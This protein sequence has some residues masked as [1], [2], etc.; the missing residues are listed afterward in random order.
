MEVFNTIECE[1]I[2]KDT[3]F[4]F[5]HGSQDGRINS[6]KDEDVVLDWL[7]G[8]ESLRGKI[9]RKKTTREIADF[10]IG[11]IPVN[12]KVSAY[13]NSQFN[14]VSSVPSLFAHC[15]NRPVK[16]NVDVA[17]NVTDIFANGFLSVDVRYYGLLII[18]KT[19]KRFWV[20]TF[21]E[22]HDDDIYVNPSNGFQVRSIPDKYVSRHKMQ[23]ISFF[24]KKVGEYYKKI[25][26]PYTIMKEQLNCL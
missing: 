4:S 20:G 15:M 22:L 16:S 18:C 25:S 10:W 12:I 26:E 23:Y 17:K 7:F 3:W 2:R 21:D 19:E 8:L 13:K 1:L 9:S 5:T 11:D 6:I 24:M 14:N